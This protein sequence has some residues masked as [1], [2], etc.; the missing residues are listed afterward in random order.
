MP[1][2]L[3]RHAAKGATA[4]GRCYEILHFGHLPH[5]LQAKKSRLAAA[6]RERL[7]AYFFSESR[8]SRSSSTSSGV[9]GGALDAMTC[10]GTGDIAMSGMCFML[11]D[12]NKCLNLVPEYLA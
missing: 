5:F 10:I 8:I 7:G 2:S 11:D 4:L 9:A 12:L 3:T 1:L 6:W